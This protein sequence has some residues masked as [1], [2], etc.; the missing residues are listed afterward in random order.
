MGLTA[1][2]VIGMVA[3]VVLGF[4]LQTI[5]GDKKEVI[6][7]LGLFDLAIKGFLVDGV[8][9]IGGQIFIAS[10]KMLVVPLV[11]I[12]LVCGSCSCGLSYFVVNSSW[13]LVGRTIAQLHF[14]HIIIRWLAHHLPLLL[15]H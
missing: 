1:R 9:H 5:L 13:N 8:F 10:L 7:P 14:D 6:I 11:F 2:I 3:G 15:L 12:S 4:I